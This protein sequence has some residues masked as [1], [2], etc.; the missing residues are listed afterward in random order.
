MKKLIILHNKIE[1]NTPDELD[2]LAQRDL[3]SK[4]CTNLGYEVMTLTV[5]DDLKNDLQKVVSSKPDIVFNIVEAT[6]GKGELIYFAPAILNAYKI[7]YTGVPLDALFVSTNKVLAKK[8]M[9]KDD[10]PTA[11]FFAINEI[12]LLNSEKKYIVK[13]IWEEASVGI[14]EDL[15]FT[16]ADSEK[17]D[18]IRQ[19]STSQYFIEEFIDGREFNVSILSGKDGPEV[20]YPAEM[21]FSE[22]FDNRP[23]IV[24]YKAKW[25]EN[26]EEYKQSKR[27]FNTLDE[28][29]ELKNKLIDICSRSWKVFN[30]HGYARI[31]FRVDFDGNI[32]ILEINGNP[33][34]A[35]DSGFIAA[36]ELAGYSNEEIMERI[37]NDLN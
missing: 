1:N 33:C 31:D 24:G 32:Y 34:I 18:K 35:P 3:V 28:D 7:P 11:P 27:S 5:G 30:L 23:K 6:W 2:V 20:L 21:I 16:M 12:H 29:M 17:T 9:L 19:L 13:P 8:I 14:S 22:Y 15:I 4:A 25:D 10:L 26:S 36:T 37:L